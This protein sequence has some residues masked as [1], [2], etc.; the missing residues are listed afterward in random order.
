[1]CVFV[2]LQG[3]AGS[4]KDGRIQIVPSEGPGQVDGRAGRFAKIDH[5]FSLTPLN[6]HLGAEE[7]GCANSE[8][9]QQIAGRLAQQWRQVDPASAVKLLKVDLMLA[10]V[11]GLPIGLSQRAR[12]LALPDVTVDAYAIDQLFGR[13]GGMPEGDREPGPSLSGSNLVAVRKAMLGIAL[14]LHVI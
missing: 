3:D 11:P 6:F 9:L 7:Q 14:D 2:E 4:L 10:E 5:E 12:M 1:M 13:R 8:D